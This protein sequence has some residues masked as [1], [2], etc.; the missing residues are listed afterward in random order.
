MEALP[1][2]NVQQGVSSAR[3]RGIWAAQLT[4]P[5]GCAIFPSG[6]AELCAMKE[7]PAFISDRWSELHLQLQIWSLNDTFRRVKFV[8][9]PPDQGT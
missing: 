6:L 5:A 7:P 1:E 2:Q 8:C 9:E 3:K 4:I